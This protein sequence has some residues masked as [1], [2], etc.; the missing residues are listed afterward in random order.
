[1]YPWNFFNLVYFLNEYESSLEKETRHL[2]VPN[3]V[4]IFVQKR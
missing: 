3:R 1:M 2:L 4:C